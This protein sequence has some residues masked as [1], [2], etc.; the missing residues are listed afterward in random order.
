MKNVGRGASDFARGFAFLG[1][2]PSLLGWVIAPALV[3]VVILAGVIY[4]AMRIAHSIVDRVASWLPSA[5]AHTGSWVVWAL[6]LA[7]LIAAAM[8]VFVAVVGVVAGPFNELLSEAVEE[9]VTGKPGP[10]FSLGSFVR[11]ALVGVA[12]AAKRLVVSIA[13]A[14]ALIAI[15]FVPV[16]G[17][18]AAMLIGWYFAARGAA[19]DC[20]DAVLARRDLTYA[21]KTRYLEANRG[22]SFGLGAVVAAL[23]IVP[24]TNLLALGVGA[25]GATLAVLE[26]G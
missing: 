1:K 10:G 9:R 17:T 5:I 11:Q 2:H 3:T 20:Y 22:R 4:L 8:V 12:H 13:G 16:I 26:E 7:A 23:L 21:Q 19:Y 14:L 24:I 18:I 15:G 6:V 25:I